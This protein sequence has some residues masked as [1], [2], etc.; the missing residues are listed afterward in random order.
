[1]V[2]Y[3]KNKDRR[4]VVKFGGSSLADGRKI[5]TAANM[6]YEALQKGGQVTVVVSAMGHTTDDLM[7]V[8]SEAA[9]GAVIKQSDLDDLLSMGERISARVLK[10]VL[11]T[12]GVEARYFDPK[13]DDWPIITNDAFGDAYPLLDECNNKIKQFINKI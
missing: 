3:K 8:T 2:K 9:N 4:L 10:S 5:S 6:I 12:L 13:D 11:K 7:K 1:M